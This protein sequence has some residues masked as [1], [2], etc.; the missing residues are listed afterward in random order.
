MRRKVKVTLLAAGVIV[1]GAAIPATGTVTG[2]VRTTDEFDQVVR[3]A[4]VNNNPDFVQVYV[5]NVENRPKAHWVEKCRGDHK[6]LIYYMKNREYSPDLFLVQQIRHQRQLDHLT[7]LMTKKLDG[8]YANVIAIP[9][10]RKQIKKKC[11]GKKKRQTNAIIYRVGRFK[12]LSAKWTWQSLAYNSRESTCKKNSQDRTVN[13]ATKLWDKKADRSVNVASIHWPSKR[14]HG[15]PCAEKNLDAVDRQINKRTGGS[16]RIFG[17]DFNINWGEGNQDWYERANGDLGGY[18]YNYRDA[19]YDDCSER[20][21][22]T[23]CLADN[24][25]FKNEKGKTRRIDF[26]FT[27]AGPSGAS[28]L[29]KIGEEATVTFDAADKADEKYTRGDKE[30]LNY[31]EHRAITARIHY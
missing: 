23:G 25:T 7:K 6:D 18:L 2:G 19:I 20:G 13:V 8:V 28:S 21:V 11:G 24:W 27:Q 15:W 5:N 9:K 3:D 10:P 16:L 31:S 29:P 26:L 1:A 14:S 17:G 12:E 30:G 4:D 22:L